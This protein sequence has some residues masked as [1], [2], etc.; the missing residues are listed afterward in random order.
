MHTIHKSR[1]RI[2]KWR[3]RK[4]NR[5]PVLVHRG[6]V[7]SR[8]IFIFSSMSCVGLRN[9]E[10]NNSNPFYYLFIFTYKCRKIVKTVGPLHAQNYLH[11]S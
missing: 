4:S 2:S 1:E 7:L 10:I 6:N 8:T 3:K 5:V 11:F 9:I